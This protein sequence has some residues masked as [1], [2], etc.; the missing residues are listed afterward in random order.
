VQVNRPTVTF[1]AIG[2][3]QRITAPAH[4]IQVYGQG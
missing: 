2:Q 3:P 4:A 1:S